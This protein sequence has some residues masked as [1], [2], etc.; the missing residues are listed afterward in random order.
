LIGDLALA[1][2]LLLVEPDVEALRAGDTVNAL[3]LDR[4]F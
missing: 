4:D 3:V 2:A 1:N